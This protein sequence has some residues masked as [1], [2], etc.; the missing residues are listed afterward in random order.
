MPMSAVFQLRV[1]S[2]ESDI[3]NM[4]QSADNIIIKNISYRY[5]WS[6]TPVLKSFQYL[7]VLF[8]KIFI[9]PSIKLRHSHLETDSFFSWFTH[10]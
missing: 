6:Q 2:S 4:A 9:N 1:E 8:K 3:L 10:Q 7:F 5:L